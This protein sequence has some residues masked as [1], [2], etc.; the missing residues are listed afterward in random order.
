MGL[1]GRLFSG[2][3]ALNIL[4]GMAQQ[5]NKI[6]DERRAEE[7]TLARDEKKA[8]ADKELTRFR[9]RLEK[10]TRLAA[11]REEFKLRKEE[12]KNK[13]KELE[14]ALF[15]MDLSQYNTL[16]DN[17]RKNFVVGK[18]INQRLKNLKDDTKTRVQLNAFRTDL[19]RDV[20][21]ELR[22]HPLFQAGSGNSRLRSK[23]QSAE[24]MIIDY[25]KQLSG[26]AD[27]GF[28]ERGD[29]TGKI[30]LAPNDIMQEMNREHPFLY[31]KY[32]KQMG[33]KNV[34]AF[35][36][37]KGITTD[38]KPK[39]DSKGDIT[40]ST[41]D[42]AANNYSYY[43]GKTD[44]TTIDMI[45]NQI[46]NID[47]GVV[48]GMGLATKKKYFDNLAR[49]YGQKDKKTIPY[50]LKDGGFMIRSA[51][52]LR[53][54]LMEYKTPLQKPEGS[55]VLKV[56][57]FFN[58][59]PDYAKFIENPE[60]A[61]AV[62]QFALPNNID[63]SVIF[64]D[65]KYRGFVESK[66]YEESVQGRLA[67][68]QERKASRVNDLKTVG[69]SKPEQVDF[70]RSAEVAKK[71]IAT[72]L[73]LL[74]KEGVNNKPAFVGLVGD[75]LV[76]FKAAVSQFNAGIEV[77]RA[78]FSKNEQGR[79][80]FQEMELVKSRALA[81]SEEIANLRATDK[82]VDAKLLIDYYAEVLTF[83]MAATIQSGSDGSVDTRT[84]SDADVK[85]IGNAL[86]VNIA[87]AI[88]GKTTVIDDIIID[89]NNKIFMLD[90]LT[91]P[92]RRKQSAAL[93]LNRYLENVSLFDQRSL[94]KYEKDPTAEE[95]GLKEI[96]AGQ[97]QFG[98]N[99]QG[100]VVGKPP[101]GGDSDDPDEEKNPFMDQKKPETPK[102]SITLQEKIGAA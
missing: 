79:T 43:G 4:G 71:R 62:I 53:Q 92:N 34:R 84:I 78:L 50:Y 77:A 40:L 67:M 7:F 96:D 88:R 75:T 48:K 41:Y 3:A 20:L 98:T 80:G 19:P 55:T 69:F 1:F 52:A 33:V 27:I 86:R 72:D 30:T 42:D 57:N 64:E 24:S 82:A 31:N 47:A 44:R 83:T 90:S 25:Y 93:I 28:T 8:E 17:L 10:D 54:D 32:L 70:K 56:R 58:N 87:N 81:L 68:E 11:I 13:P 91:A 2:G 26:E 63:D 15:R 94:L 95:L 60:L 5:Y 14:P 49:A 65:V 37:A 102:K 35:N 45:D 85:R 101:I 76:N 73:R 29:S 99:K 18:N 100:I 74:I 12:E 9:A 46:K 16:P 23:L 66:P 59:S 61:L 22:Q 89:A 39:I 36:K 38:D 21:E 97:A 6:S 51:L